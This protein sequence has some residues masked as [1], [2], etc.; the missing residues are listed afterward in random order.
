MGRGDAVHI[1]H[2]LKNIKKY[3][4]V[5]FIKHNYIE[6]N[7][8]YITDNTRYDIL[9]YNICYKEFFKQ[10]KLLRINKILSNIYTKDILSNIIKK[11]K[12]DIIHERDSTFSFSPI[13]LANKFR[14]PYFVEIN[15][16]ISMNNLIFKNIEKFKENSKIHKADAIITVS[17]TLRTYF[18]NKGLPDNKIYVVPNGVDET[19]FNPFVDGKYVKIKYNLEGFRVICFSGSTLQKW[20]GIDILMKTAMMIQSIKNIKFLIVGEEIRDKRN[21]PENVVF[22]GSIKHEDV[23]YYLAAADILVAPYILIDKFIKIGFFNSPIKLFEYMAMGKAII[24]SDMGQIKEVI[25]HGKTGIL[26]KPNDP[27]EL[28]EAIMRL[29]DDDK[30][31]TK[32]GNNAW[33]SVLKNYT[34]ENNADAINR[35]YTK[36]C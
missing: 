7:K 1:R 36:F 5:F 14:L 24:S 32:L 2:F 25:E 9:Q 10:E 31:R 30:L 34:W 11:E 35:I 21:I 20:Q 4:E 23:P 12:P 27:I 13:L 29:L 15:S 33:E 3:H 8:E 26:I 18:R 16:P 28:T 19:I 6:N 22:T 17:N